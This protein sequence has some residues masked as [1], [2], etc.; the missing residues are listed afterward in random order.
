MGQHHFSGYWV[1]NSQSLTK[2]LI[3]LTHLSAV[4]LGGGVGVGGVHV[5]VITAKLCWKRP[6]KVHL[7]RKAICDLYNKNVLLT[8]K[9]HSGKR[10]KGEMI[11]IRHKDRLY[12]WR[13][14]RTWGL[15]QRKEFCSLR[16]KPQDQG[17]N[18]AQD[19]GGGVQVKAGFIE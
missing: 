16:D 4:K 15:S 8:D 1:K 11:C 12:W 14:Q 17:L 5:T 7:Y 18:N 3:F 13:V 10:A 9:Q 2:L 6:C 19:M